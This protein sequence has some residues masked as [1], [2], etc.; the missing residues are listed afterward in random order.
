MTCRPEAIKS[1]KPQFILVRDNDP[2]GYDTKKGKAAELA[3]RIDVLSLSK[4]SPDI[5]APDYVFHHEARP[6][7]WMTM[8]R[9][10]SAY[11]VRRLPACASPLAPPACAACLRRLPAPPACTACL[12][13][14]PAPPDATSRQKGALIKQPR[15]PVHGWLLTLAQYRFG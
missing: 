2:K 13:R 6:P 10:L 9:T 5:C 3:N 15:V 8:T 7:A 12:H 1:V 11:R 4:Y 14:L